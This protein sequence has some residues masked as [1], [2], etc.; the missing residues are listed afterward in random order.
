MKVLRWI[1][2]AKLIRIYIATLFVG[3]LK[4]DTYCKAVPV[5]FSD[6]I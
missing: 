5:F 1:F 6:P 3:C 2:I 4:G